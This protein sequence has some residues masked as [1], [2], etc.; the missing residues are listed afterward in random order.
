MDEFKD[1]NLKE[2]VEVKNNSKKE[3]KKRTN[4]GILIILLIIDTIIIV[5]LLWLLL[6]KNIDNSVDNNIQEGEVKES[7]YKISG[8]SLGDFDL[9]FLKLE[10]KIEN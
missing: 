5:T 9:Q 3:K 10:N 6:N 4:T 1:V 2:E 7:Q 8:S